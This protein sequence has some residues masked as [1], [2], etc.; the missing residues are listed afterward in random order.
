MVVVLRDVIRAE[1]AASGFLG[2]S[3]L[4]WRS[5]TRTCSKGGGVLGVLVVFLWRLSL[6]G[7]RRC[8]LGVS[9][10]GAGSCGYCQPLPPCAVVLNF[11]CMC[12]LYF[13]IFFPNSSVMSHFAE[14][15]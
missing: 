8:R 13:M 14:T 4:L 9:R 7:Q 6:A 11:S 2:R 10:P 15:F 12:G 3:I 1:A 5:R